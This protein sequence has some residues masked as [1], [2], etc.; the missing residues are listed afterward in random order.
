MSYLVVFPF[1]MLNFPKQ[2][3]VSRMLLI[4]W[5]RWPMSRPKSMEHEFRCM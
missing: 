2:L 4:P 5:C 1:Q 3:K